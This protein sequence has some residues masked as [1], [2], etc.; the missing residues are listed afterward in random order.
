MTARTPEIHDNAPVT[1]AECSRNRGACYNRRSKTVMIV[2]GIVCPILGWLAIQ[3]FADH[4]RIVRQ[5]EKLSAY[6]R[7]ITDMRED[8]REIK[9]LLM[10]RKAAAR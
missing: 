10:E 8:V 4:E 5:E 7:T 1:V 3:A 6:E 2:W 9:A